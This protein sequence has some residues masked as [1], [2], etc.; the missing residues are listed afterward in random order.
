MKKKNF[1]YSFCIALCCFFCAHAQGPHESKIPLKYK[2]FIDVESG[3]AYNLN[4]AQLISTNNMQVL[5]CVTTTHGL[6]IKNA[7][8]GVGIG[9][10]HSVRDDENIYPIFAAT[11]LVFSKII[12]KPFVELRTGIA[13]DPQWISSV[14]YY[15]A[16]SC[17]FN[18]LKKIQLGCRISMFSR[19][20]RYFTVNA[21]IMCGIAF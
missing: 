9:Y 11:R 5:Y 17:G 7:F 19:P 3:I 21:S 18:V 20:S 15:G 4:T 2:G 8:V 6:Q 14:Q 13:Y 12:V 1:I 16:L 10:Y